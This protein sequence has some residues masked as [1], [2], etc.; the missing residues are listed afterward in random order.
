M[1][2]ESAIKWL[3]VTD[4]IGHGRR[5]HHITEKTLDRFSTIVENDKEENTTCSDLLTELD[6]YL[7]AMTIGAQAA[8][9][10]FRFE[11]NLGT[12][13]AVMVGNLTAVLMK[14]GERIYLHS[15]DG[16]V[17]GIF[18]RTLHTQHF[19]LLHNHKLAVLS[20]GISVSCG[21]SQLRE[22]FSGSA[23]PGSAQEQA[24]Q[25][26]ERCGRDYDDA[27]CFLVFINGES[28]D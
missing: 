19:S 8:M 10:L 2:G 3:L 14:E 1:V 17:G 4:A 11:L 9:A 12:M 24:Q 16:M 21:M 20:D 5:A 25:I 26:V 6:T 15:R 13:E 7:R 23:A 18:P 22:L 28:H 27:S